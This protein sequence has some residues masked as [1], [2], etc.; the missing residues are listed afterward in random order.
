VPQQL[1]L[2]FKPRDATPEEFKEWEEKELN[3]WAE[4]QI[5]LV[6]FMAIVQLLVFGSMLMAFYLIGK[7]V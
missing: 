6:A 7:A 2:N 4:I 1:N 3:W 5:P